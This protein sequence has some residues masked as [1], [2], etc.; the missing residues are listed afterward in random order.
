MAQKAGVSVTT[1]SRV[2]NNSKPVSSELRER[3]ERVIKETGFA[4]SEVARGLVHRKTKLI[5]LMIPKVANTFFSQ[6]IEGAEQVA[7]ANGFNI[8][9][10]VSHM[11]MEKEVDYL[12]IFKD[13]QLDGIIFSVSQFTNLHRQFF[14]EFEIPT[15]F[16]GQQIKET[17]YPYILIDNFKASYEATKYL[18]NKGHEKIGILKGPDYDISTGYE[19]YRGYQQALQDAGLAVH[20]DWVFSDFHDI[21]NGYRGMKTIMEQDELPTAMFACS[22]VMA[23]GAINYLQDHGFRIPQDMSIIGFDDAE[24]STMFRPKLTTIRQDSFEMGAEA[25]RCLIEQIVEKKTE[26]KE[27]IFPH[28]LIERESTA[29]TTNY[30]R[31]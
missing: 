24:L 19:R 6:L 15:V 22:D 3:V 18:I 9:L 14:N 8:L 26:K 21:N 5:G 31:R 29:E 7:K 13:R 2:I 23:V 4:P 27:I 17:P 10:T 11:D 28:Q 20:D 1:V 25:M 16:L 30:L 12:S